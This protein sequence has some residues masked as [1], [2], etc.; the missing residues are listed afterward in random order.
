MPTL[1]KTINTVD[2]RAELDTH[3]V[4]LTTLTELWIL[5]SIQPNYWNN[6][7]DG[8]SYLS[9]V[10]VNS[11]RRSPNIGAGHAFGCG[12]VMYGP[13]PP[14]GVCGVFAFGTQ[15]SPAARN[16][17]MQSTP[18]RMARGDAGYDWWGE[19]TR[20]GGQ[21]TRICVCHE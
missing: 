11:G 2:K 13:C 5:E 6:S 19:Q 3:I 8:Q 9:F 16:P 12:Y 14:T 20:S 1:P 7:E 18:A 21:V 10:H 4:E 17:H 15:L